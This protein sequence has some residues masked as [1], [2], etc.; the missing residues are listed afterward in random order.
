MIEKLQSKETDLVTAWLKSMTFQEMKGKAQ[1][2]ADRKTDLRIFK[3]HGD[4]AHRD[5]TKPQPS[6]SHTLEKA[7]VAE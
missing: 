4:Q 6:H 2:P 7:R 3:I 5:Q 1:S